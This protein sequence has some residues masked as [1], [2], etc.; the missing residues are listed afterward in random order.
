MAVTALRPLLRSILSVVWAFLSLLLCRFGKLQ[1]V[2]VL[3]AT[4]GHG[5]VSGSKA[6]ARHTAARH[7]T[8]PDYIVLRVDKDF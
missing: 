5:R 4:K 3:K 1:S 7:R 6:N 2:D 8:L